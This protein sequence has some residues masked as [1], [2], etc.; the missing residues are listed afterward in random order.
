MRA[1]HHTGARICRCDLAGL[2]GRLRLG[3]LP[4]R[5]LLAGTLLGFGRRLGLRSGFG[6]TGGAFGGAE[7]RGWGR[8]GSDL[9][10]G[11]GFGWK[12]RFQL[13]F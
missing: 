3:L 11:L 6:H 8:E 9:L 10:A 5:S 13:L 2:R 1:R 7:G 12:G 4:V